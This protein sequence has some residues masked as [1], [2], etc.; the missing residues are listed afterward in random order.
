MH[1]KLLFYILQSTEFGRHVNKQK[2]P[3]ILEELAAPKV[4][5]Q[6]AQE[7]VFMDFWKFEVGDTIGS[8]LAAQMSFFLYIK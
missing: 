2:L 7:W 5:V 6:E 8:A 3:N 4:K 1:C